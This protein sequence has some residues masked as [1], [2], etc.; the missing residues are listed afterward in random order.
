M[1]PISKELRNLSLQLSH[2]CQDGNLQSVFSCM[3]IVWTLYDKVMH[4]SPELAQDDDRD[5][6]IISKGQAT[7]ALFPILI[8]KGMFTLDE[9]HDIGAFDSR[10][11]IQTDITKFSGGVENAAGSLGHGFPFAVGIAM[12]NKI[13]KSPS[14][15]FVLVGD[16][17]FC[18]GTMWESCIVAG[19]KKLD[20]LTVIIDDNDSVGAMIDLG[21]MAAKL[22]AF[23]FDVW[24]V[25]GHNL[26]ALEETFKASSE[27]NGKPKAVIAKT[28]RGYGSKTLTDF[29]VWFHKSP[30]AEELPMLMQEVNSF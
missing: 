15:V 17:E 14:K 16:G 23:G 8:K 22:E 7:L 10:F 30:N 20:N 29:D 2:M 1:E 28:V 11:C 6:F 24:T 21:D 25:D 4:W 9:M 18:E 19:G 3:D 12:A 13:K 5:F 27:Q 26:A